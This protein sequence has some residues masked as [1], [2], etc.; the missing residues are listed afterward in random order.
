MIRFLFFSKGRSMGFGRHKVAN[1]QDELEKSVSNL[2]E[3]LANAD[4][5]NI[6]EV[7]QLRKRLDEGLSEVQDSAIDVVHEAKRHA[8]HAA[9]ATNEYVHD[10]PWQIVG[11]A[12]AA[13][14]VLG[15]LLGRR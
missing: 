5:D 11:G 7:R 8:R 2:R 4:L 1:A 10:E 3:L 14:V 6:P 15:F 13:G 12:L 9:R